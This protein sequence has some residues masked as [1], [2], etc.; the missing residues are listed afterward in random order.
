M[1]SF[2]SSDRTYTMEWTRV[3]IKTDDDSTKGHLGLDAKKLD[4]DTDAA[5]M[6]QEFL[7]SLHHLSEVQEMHRG[8]VSDVSS[9]PL[10][11]TVSTLGEFVSEFGGE[12]G[13]SD[14]RVPLPS[15]LRDEIMVHTKN[16]G[17]RQLVRLISPERFGGSIKTFD[18][19]HGK[20][21]VEAFWEGDYLS[22]TLG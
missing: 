14:V 16:E 6:H 9:K 11:A 1:G 18:L 5:S 17:G 22:M 12:W 4:L 19:P 8:I 15:S 7:R 13:G 10:E 3:H 20:D 21:L 2:G